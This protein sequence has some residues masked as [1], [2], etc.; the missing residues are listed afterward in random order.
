MLQY[1]V[2]RYPQLQRDVDTRNQDIAGT[3]P[4]RGRR[5]RQVRHRHGLVH[6]GAAED[7]AGRRWRS[8]SPQTPGARALPVHHPR[9]LPPAGARARREGRA[10]ALAS[11][12]RFN[13]TPRATFQELSTSDIKFPK[14]TLG[15]GKEV[16]LTPRQLPGAARRPTTTRRTAP[17]PSR[18]TSR[19]TRPRRTPTPRST[20]AS[21]SATGSSPRRA[22]SRPRSTR[23]STATRSRRAVVETLVDTTR[24][25]T[26]AAPALRCGCARSCSGST[27]YHLYDGLIPDLPGRTRP[28]PTSRRATSCSRRSRRSA[29]DY[30]AEVP[31]ASSRAAASTSTRTTASAAAP[32]APASTASAPTC[33]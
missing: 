23:R 12:A 3:L 25:G 24:A 13:Q 31:E 6:A 9:Q 28:I 21:C 18:P 8:G 16:T 19:P 1:R 17:R 20:T 7:P 33:C 30:V 22:T 14:V 27:T 15:D 2:Y 10:A 11:P 29:A 26:G 4:A 5:L 32:T